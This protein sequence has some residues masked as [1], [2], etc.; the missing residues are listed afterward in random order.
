MGAEQTLPRART[1]GLVVQELGDE[2]LVYDRESDVA[3]CLSPIAAR[4]WRACDGRRDLPGLA[5]LSAASEDVVAEA[6]AELWKKKLLVAE[7]WRSDE[8]AAGV[9]RRRALRRIGLAGL[10]AAPLPLIVSAVVGTPLAAASGGMCVACTGSGPTDT[11]SSGYQCDPGISQCIL[12]A[13]NSAATLGATCTSTGARCAV[14]I[15][16]FGTCTEGC[17]TGGFLCCT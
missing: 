9:S 17:P 5:R 2:S 4:V 3:H 13:C 1:E 10:A 11:C 16:D 6:V 15:A 12:S 14:G 8:P 7:P